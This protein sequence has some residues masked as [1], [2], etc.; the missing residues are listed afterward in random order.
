MRRKK[1]ATPLKEKGR[2]IKYPD[3][4]LTRKMNA[5]GWD[6]VEDFYWKSTVH[7]IT[8]KDTVRRLILHEEKIIEPLFIK[9]LESLGFTPNE[10]RQQLE[11]WGYRDF[12]NL[13]GGHDGI[14]A[15]SKEAALISIYRSL[16][17]KN[18]DVAGAIASFFEGLC[19]SLKID[20]SD[21]LNQLKG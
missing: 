16:V 11:K 7:E 19:I 20:C 18:P 5:M 15:D 9:I 12:K 3:N 6:L 10:I 13:I 4:D 17:L 8:S 14:S 2:K 21:S 1:T